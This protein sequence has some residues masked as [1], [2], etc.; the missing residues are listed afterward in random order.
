VPVLISVDQFGRYSAL[1]TEAGLLAQ[2]ALLGAPQVILRRG[3]RIGSPSWLVFH[4]L[5]LLALSWYVSGVFL[6]LDF[7]GLVYLLA[8]S[9]VLQGIAGAWSRRNGRFMTAVIGE[10]LMGVLLV[11]GG[12][13]AALGAAFKT[14]ESVS[15]FL[16]CEAIAGLAAGLWLL[17]RGGSRIEKFALQRERVVYKGVLREIYDIGLL[18]LMDTILWR[19]IEVLFLERGNRLDAAAVFALSLQLGELACLPMAAMLEAWYPG[20]SEVLAREGSEWRCDWR[21]RRRAFGMVLLA[22]VPLALVSVVMLV[23]TPLLRHYSPWT[24]TILILVL[25]KVVLNY[26]S[27]YS[28]ALYAT[29]HQ[30]QLYLPVLVASVIKLGSNGLLTPRFGLQGAV[31]AYLMSH[32]YLAVATFLAARNFGRL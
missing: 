5:T 6:R 30:R 28:S 24:A 1:R 17:V 7:Q 32:G 27:L 26:A 31:V 29:G 13:A 12:T 20:L 23:H 3:T 15:W 21:R 11:V 9:Q 8:A 22:S 19:R 2:L 16:V 25:A 10:G 14:R 18:V 4:S